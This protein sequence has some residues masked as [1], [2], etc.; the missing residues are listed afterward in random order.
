ME[1]DAGRDVGTLGVGLISGVV[2]LRKISGEMEEVGVRLTVTVAEMEA[3][4]WA[5]VVGEE[6]AVFDISGRSDV[7]DDRVWK[8]EIEVGGENSEVGVRRTEVGV[9][10][11][12]V[13]GCSGLED[14]LL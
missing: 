13:D 2:E 11:T 8:S 10:K 7:K 9:R 6:E 3:M 5:E 14:G 12:E 1:E 4:P